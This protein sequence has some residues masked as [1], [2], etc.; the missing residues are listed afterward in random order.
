MADLQASF[1]PSNKI[2]KTNGREGYELIYEYNG[3]RLLLTGIGLNGFRASAH[4]LKNRKA[5]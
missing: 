3:E 2:K 4:P 1:G 5:Q